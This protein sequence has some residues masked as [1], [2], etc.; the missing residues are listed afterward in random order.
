M[1]SERDI[2]HTHFGR[3]DKDLATTEYRDRN[4]AG[5]DVTWQAARSLLREEVKD[6]SQGP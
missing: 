1:Q 3:D 6:D 4:T 5:F 2:F